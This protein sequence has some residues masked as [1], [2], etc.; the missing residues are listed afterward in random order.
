MHWACAYGKPNVLKLLLEKDYKNDFLGD[1]EPGSLAS[2]QIKEG[3]NPLS[4]AIGNRNRFVIKPNF[5]IHSLFMN[6][7]IMF[8][9]LRGG[10]RQ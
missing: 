7:V 4:L 5:H 3:G 10:N 1:P 2:G 8:K 9:G 6:K